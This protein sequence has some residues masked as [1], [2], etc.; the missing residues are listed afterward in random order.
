MSASTRYKTGRNK[1]NYNH[2]HGLPLSILELKKTRRLPSWKW[3]WTRAGEIGLLADIVRP[4]IAIIT[5][6]ADVNI[7]LMKNLDNYSGYKWR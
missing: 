6:I 3:G 1:K 2:A 7:E 4:D 5:K